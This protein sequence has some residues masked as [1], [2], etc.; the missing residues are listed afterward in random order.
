MICAE[1][2]MIVYNALTADMLITTGKSMFTLYI[3]IVTFSAK[4]GMVQHIN[5]VRP[6][7]RYPVAV[8]EIYIYIYTHVHHA[9]QHTSTFRVASTQA[10]NITQKRVDRVSNDFQ[11]RWDL[12]Q[13]RN[14]LEHFGDVPFNPLNIGN[15]FPTFVGIRVC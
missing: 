7:V 13:L 12:V 10:D 8:S 11:D 6:P 2:N 3:C 4:T 9:A 1:Q 5:N 14:N 15:F